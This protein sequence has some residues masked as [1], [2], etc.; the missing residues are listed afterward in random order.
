VLTARAPRTNVSTLKLA[1]SRQLEGFVFDT[2]LPLASFL[3]IHPQ[4]SGANRDTASRGIKRHAT[5]AVARVAL[6]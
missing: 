6:A 2:A 4:A 3:T 5:I 1:Y